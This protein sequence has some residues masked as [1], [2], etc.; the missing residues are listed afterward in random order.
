MLRAWLL[1]VA[2]AGLGFGIALILAE[3]LVG[4][5]LPTCAQDLYET[6]E[7]IGWALAPG[8][9]TVYAPCAHPWST[10]R[11]RVETNELGLRDVER[12]REKSEGVFRILVL[13][14]SFTEALQVEREQAFVARLERLLNERTGGTPRVEVWNAGVSGYGTDNE[15][16]AYRERYRGFGA[17]L[18]LLVMSSE[19]DIYENSREILE[20]GP[21]PYPDKPYFTIDASGS[22][23]LRNQPVPRYD[24]PP[25]SYRVTL[26][27]FVQGSALHRAATGEP[28]P[29]KRRTVRMLGGLGKAGNELLVQHYLDEDGDA[30]TEARRLTGRIL[31]LLAQEVADSGARLAVVVLP[32]KRALHPELLGL[33]LARVGLAERPHRPAGP[34]EK[35]L[36]LVEERDLPSKGILPVLTALER[37]TGHTGFLVDNTHFSV[38]GHEAVAQ[39]M[40]DFLVAERLVP[41][42]E[43]R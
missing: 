41:G 34:Y 23:T 39:S 14:D 31:D 10:I 33:M 40:A 17:D 4:A 6:D 27:E 26:E 8:L 37:D 18:V 9:Q 11:T 24:P 22:L 36:A 16:L 38:R 21:L 15:L 7:R 28:P 42:V 3:L 13:G 1:R 32:D 25:R 12:S 20:K 35:L 29:L 30:W 19:N 43:A 2:L 5:F